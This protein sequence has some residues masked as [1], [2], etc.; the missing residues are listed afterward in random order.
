VVFIAALQVGLTLSSGGNVETS[1][2]IVPTKAV[3][4]HRILHRNEP[5]GKQCPLDINIDNPACVEQLLVFV[6]RGGSHSFAYDQT[7][8]AEPALVLH[9]D[10]AILDEVNWSSCSSHKFMGTTQIDKASLLRSVLSFCTLCNS[11]SYYVHS[12]EMRDEE[13]SPARLPCCFINS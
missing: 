8:E 11:L 10:S 12:V 1:K 4:I 7:A 9:Q 3:R 2:Y 5:D 6:L 13:K